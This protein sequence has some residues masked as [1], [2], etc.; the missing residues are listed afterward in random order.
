VLALAVKKPSDGQDGYNNESYFDDS[1][2][3]RHLGA[4]ISY[5][6]R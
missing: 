1:L 4:P 2:I 6:Q 5:R 3:P